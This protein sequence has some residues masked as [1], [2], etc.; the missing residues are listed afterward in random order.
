MNDRPT[1][2]WQQVD[3]IYYR[4]LET[5]SETRSEYLDAA[6]AGDEVLRRE[7]ESLLEAT[8][9]MGDDFLGTPL[10]PLDLDPTPE[11]VDGRRLGAYRILREIARGGM[12]TVYLAARADDEFEREVAVKIL[13]RGLDTDE[14]VGRFRHERQILAQL[15]HPHISRLLDGGTTE[16]GLPYLVMEKVKGE[17]ID[18]WCDRQRLSVRDRLELFCKVCSAVQFAHQ[19]LVVHRD[20]KPANILVDEEGKPTRLDFGIAKLLEPDA[21]RLT[22]AG[23]RPM[24]LEHAS[25][26]QIRGEP[27]TTSSD[28][29][30]LGGLL[31]ELLAGRSPHGDLRGSPEMIFHRVCNEEPPPPSHTVAKAED[32]PSAEEIAGARSTDPRSLR[33][34]LAGDLDSIVLKA[35]ERD[36]ERRYRSA[37]QLAEDLQRHL[38][39]E[40]VTARAA[41]MPYRAGRFVRRHWVGVALTA[42]VMVLIVGLGLRESVLRGRAETQRQVA[43][44]QR[45]VAEAVK[46]YMVDIFRSSNPEQAQGE[47]VTVRQ[48]LDE[49]SGKILTHRTLPPEVRA[50]LMDAMGYSYL[51]LGLYEAAEPLL[52]ESL[53]LHRQSP[54]TRPEDLA[55]TLFH[56]VD[57]RRTQDRR[58]EAEALADEGLALLRERGTDPGA[59][60]R[61]LTHRAGLYKD[62]GDLKAA[63]ALYRESLA[64]KI[65]HE[66]E[67]SLDVATG[68]DKLGVVLKEEGR[69][70]EAEQ[71]YRESMD[72][73]HRL[74]NDES[75]GLASVQNNLAVLLQEKGD[76][77]A[78]EDLFRE[79]LPLRCK[80]YG[81][82]HRKVANSLNNLAFVLQLQGRFE[83]AEPLYLEAMKILSMR[84]GE[85]RR[86]VAAIL[87]NLAQLELDRGDPERAEAR[88]RRALEIF[89][90]K[91][92]EGHWHLADAKSVLG[93]ALAAQGR[94]AEAEPRLR[95]SLAALE[96]AGAPERQTREARERLARFEKDRP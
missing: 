14:I 59:L 43:E 30:A 57:L 69:L 19:R 67:E 23:L 18:R 26:E 68:R 94:R 92:P 5:P 42:A 90:S 37:E 80:V 74:G 38:D 4:A 17:R 72:L 56:L 96:A 91:L 82:D 2:K 7:V 29:Y 22:R 44:N 87:R 65:E 64:L 53:R 27:V 50:G 52:V 24:T 32:G 1:E 40:P 81:D 73:H 35:L 55:T 70:D 75:T 63:E 20:L 93:A 66:G 8:E 78:A 12:G 77:D 54:E 34:R 31:Y 51:G 46:T 49:K 76:L 11:L 48:I 79:N 84:L 71:L 58:E 33:R 61:G 41:S 16:D 15:T 36:P 95:E 60:A 13:K 88:I 86:E 89:R 85:G 6:C 28:V 47:E 39:G 83:E 45:R 3:E 9:A 21:E 25:P 62:A 10:L